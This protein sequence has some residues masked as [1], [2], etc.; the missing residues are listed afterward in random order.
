MP[1]A[2]AAAIARDESAA[3]AATGGG[4]VAVIADGSRHADIAEALAGAD[5][6]LIDPR[7]SK[8]LEFDIVIVVEPAQIAARPGD[9][10]VAMTRPTQRLVFVHSEP[11]PDGLA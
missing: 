11:L 4:L 1:R 2:R 10:Y 7:E 9:L 5:V 3:L 8:G 6:T